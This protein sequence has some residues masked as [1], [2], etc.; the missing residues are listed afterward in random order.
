MNYNF[1]LPN[2][3]YYSNPKHSTF[4]PQMNI[5]FENSNNVKNELSNPFNTK[6]N[7]IINGLSCLSLIVLKRKPEYAMYRKKQK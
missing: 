3:R 5:Y 7:K 6:N 1:H 2:G 4:T